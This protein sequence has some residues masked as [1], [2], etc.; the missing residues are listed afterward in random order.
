MRHVILA[1]LA[2]ALVVPT[3]VLAHDVMI[4]KIE[5][6]LVAHAPGVDFAVWTKQGLQRLHAPS[7][8]R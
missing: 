5:D 6:R 2:L 7:G 1:S 8:T 3:V 4:I